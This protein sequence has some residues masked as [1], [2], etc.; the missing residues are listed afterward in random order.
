M[1]P[2]AC[3][4]ILCALLPSSLA[5]NM[6]LRSGRVLKDASV[7][8]SG[9]DFVSVQYTDGVAKVSYK[10]LTDEQQK[11]YK[12]T[13]DEVA[14]RLEKRRSEEAVRRQRAEAVKKAA[15]EEARKI[16]ESLSEAERHPRYLEGEDVVR[17]FLLMGDLSRVE[18]EVIALQWNAQEADRVGLPQDAKVFR[19]RARTYQDQISSIR[20]KREDAELYWKDLEK[21]YLALKDGTQK[22][23][24]DLNKQVNQ[25]QGEIREVASQPKTERVVVTPIVRPWNYPPPPVIIRPNPPSPPPRPQPVPPPVRPIQSPYGTTIGR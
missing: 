22:K 5:E 21:K 2:G 20:K 24:T 13:P 18:A 12:M 10:E 8:S 15:E 23:I 4:L 7:V 11:A 19:T 17:M 14:A 3:L 1:K 25:L 16:R 6:A 9:D